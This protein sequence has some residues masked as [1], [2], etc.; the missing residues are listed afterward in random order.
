[1]RSL[2]KKLEDLS[3]S[4]NNT[5]SN[6]TLSVENKKIGKECSFD[7]NIPTYNLRGMSLSKNRDRSSKS[8]NKRVHFTV[9]EDAEDEPN[10]LKAFKE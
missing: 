8:Q 9:L 7:Q 3:I 4:R 2:S 1:M 6:S 10:F 5:F